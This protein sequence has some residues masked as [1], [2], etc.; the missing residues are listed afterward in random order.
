VVLLTP[1]REF[2]EP[3]PWEQAELVVDT[4]NTVPPG[5]NV[6]SI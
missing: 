4:R 3:D 2:A 6:H 5:P 1:H